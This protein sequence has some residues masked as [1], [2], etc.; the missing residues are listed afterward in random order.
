M[1]D[2]DVLFRSIKGISYISIAPLIVLTASLWFTPDNLATVLAHLAQLYFSVLLF[3]L[4]GNIWSIKGK[5]NVLASKLTY[6][7]LMPVLFAIVGGVL[8]FFVTPIWGI[9]FLLCAVY[10]SRHFQYVTSITK[11]LNK[12]Y[13]DLINKISIILCIC[14]MLIL[15]YWLNPYTNPIEIYN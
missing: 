2:E 5:K 1:K 7:S 14:L 9:S 8:T 4:F 15:V 10:A 11:T 13:V 12:N 3:F 6:I